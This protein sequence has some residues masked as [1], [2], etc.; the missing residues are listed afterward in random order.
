[1]DGPLDADIARIR[2]A[3]DG[4]MRLLVARRDEPGGAWFLVPELLEREGA[5]AVLLS[6]ISGMAGPPPDH[7]RA[8]W[9]FESYARAL[10]DLGCAF[11]VS[12]G[13]LPDLSPTNLLMAARGGL[14][15]GTALR[16]NRFASGPDLAGALRDSLVGLISP[17]ATWFDSHGLRPEKTLWKSAADRIAESAL[18]A[19]RAFDRESEAAVLA[20]GLLAAPGPLQIPL[21]KM[22][23][24]RG[25]E[26]HLRVTCC[27]AYRATGGQVC[28]ACPLNR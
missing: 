27:L 6:R 15:A 23:D 11:I 9:L 12:A 20:D 18:W 10:G 22:V 21:E 24:R 25:V 26:R 19:G 5:P 1:V 17:L 28:A 3:S 2:A 4:G 16:S 7:V 8:E 14:I 13:K